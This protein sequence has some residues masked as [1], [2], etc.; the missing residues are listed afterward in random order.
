MEIS[1]LSSSERAALQQGHERIQSGDW[2]RAEAIL[3]VV[4]KGG[5]P[6]ALHMLAFCVASQGRRDEARTLLEAAIRVASRHAP[7]WASYGSNFSEMGD[8][9]SAVTAFEQATT[10]APV[11]GE[12]WYSLGLAQRALG[13][14]EAAEKSLVRAGSLM[15]ADA[16]IPALRGLIAREL[17]HT[18]SAV[19]HFRAALALDPADVRTRHNLA[20]ALR[21]LDEPSAALA[22]IGQAIAGGATFPETLSVRGHLL[23]ELGDADGAVAQYRAVIAAAPEHL[24]AHE[25]LARLLP[26][27]GRGDEALEGYGA[28]LKR[29]PH[30]EALWLSALDAARALNDAEALLRW[31]QAAERS[32]GRRI[33]FSIA[34]AVANGLV[35]E[36]GNA[37]SIL[38]KLSVEHPD[39][40]A[41]QAHLSHTLLCLSD[42]EAA[43]RYA[44]A[45]TRL[46]PLDQTGWAHLTIIWR[47]LHDPREYWLAD[48][49]R[50]VM[51]IDIDLPPD[52]QQALERLHVTQ[53][54]P[55]EQSVRG[56]TQTRGFLFERRD[57]AIRAIAE[58]INSAVVAKL[59][60]LPD[61]PTHPF[62]SRKAK[63]IA[64]SGAWS[65][66]LGSAGFHINHIH[67]QGWISSALYV[68]LPETIDVGSG[69]LAF[70]V[71]DAAFGLDLTPRRIEIPSPGK[72]VIFPSY[73]WHG[74]LP[75][76][77]D[78]P[79]L[80]LAFDALP[81]G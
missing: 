18:E 75:F 1:A 71:P 79:R 65:V 43:E 53:M 80:T 27:I 62:L 12:G 55:A 57:P 49:E 7:Y 24:D 39:N 46:A 47:L 14:L 29:A 21:A 2:V 40:P 76:V 32:V 36:H 56:G 11:N 44:L 31:A 42:A 60:T 19:D 37:R 51:P 26:Q 81:Q 23:G 72:L 6:E 41:I 77:S 34:R 38:E 54:H 69:A 52:L 48:Y 74:T 8:Y 13:Q 10:L 58:R 50:L 64:F 15:A 22:E 20:V 30:S 33:A 73:L 3:S 25:T 9:A 66:R 4:A 45:A 59:M 63:A 78:T 68:A 61:D 16:R 35:G 70:G 28:A 17:G 67:P 5:H